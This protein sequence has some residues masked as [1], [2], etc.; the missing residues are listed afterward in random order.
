MV[1]VVLTAVLVVLLAISAMALSLVL[2]FPIL[3]SGITTREVRDAESDL[4]ALDNLIREVAGEGE[5]AARRFNYNSPSQ[6]R[7]IASDD[8]IEF[9]AQV[10]VEAYDYL[11]RTQSGNVIFINGHDV[12]CR[13]AD[14]NGDGTTD[15]VLENQLVKFVFNRTQRI[16]PHSSI[17][18]TLSILSI[19]DK[20][21]SVTVNPV[22]A[23]V[24]IDGSSNNGTGFS[25]ILDA[26]K[27]KPSCAAHFFINATRSYDI[28][29]RLYT[30]ADF[31][32]MEV[33]NIK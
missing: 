8:A 11:S 26:G 13:E 4:R 33:R 28:F 2:G 32:V 21:N 31:A 17:D 16:T 9:S 23:S 6:F 24:R 7:A 27:G 25:E 29:Y 3:T 5:G 19:T 12:D 15:L 14:D 18:T 10:D 30:G 20:T 1:N 22:N